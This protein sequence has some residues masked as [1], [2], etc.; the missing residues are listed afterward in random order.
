MGLNVL[1]IIVSILPVAT[2]LKL[3]LFNSYSYWTTFLIIEGWKISIVFG[4]IVHLVMMKYSFSILGIGVVNSL[5]ILQFFYI[6]EIELVTGLTD[7]KQFVITVI[8][9]LSHNIGLFYEY[10]QVS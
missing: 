10:Y 9:A 5:S 2:I 3:L 7:C 8:F 6:F 4:K 1:L